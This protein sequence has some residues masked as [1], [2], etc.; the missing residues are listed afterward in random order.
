MS[1]ITCNVIKDLLELY[2]DDVVS[3]DT[4]ALVEDHLSSCTMCNEKLA[5][6]RQNLSIP[7]EVSAEPI[8]QI[9]RKIK[10]KNI[11]VS[12]ISIAIVASILLGGFIF[13]TQYEVAIPFEKTHIYN[14]EQADNDW[15]LLIHFMDNI[16]S[17]AVLNSVNYD[18]A[19]M[20]I[21]IHFKDTI[22]RRYFS[23]HN[24]VSKYLS[25]PAYEGMSIELFPNH[26]ELDI[27]IDTHDTLPG[28]FVRVE[29]VRVYYS[30]WPA[31]QRLPGDPFGEKH[32]L[33]ERQVG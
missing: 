33:W 7:A 9:K 16:E 22:S 29:T 5:Q 25:V 27:T 32:L 1:R 13:L 10:K 3:E 6:I 23:N 14:V 2:S 21:Y 31:K 12:V 4:K 15:E 8:K 28:E 18:D 11:V 20:E 26:E 30:I 17:Y 19:T 24:N